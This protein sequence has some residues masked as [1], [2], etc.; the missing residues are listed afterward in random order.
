MTTTLREELRLQ[1][2]S[3]ETY[4]VY[5]RAL[6]TAR[7]TRRRVV[8]AGVAAIAG[9]AALGLTLPAAVPP[10]RPLTEA[11]EAAGA[12][13]D[14][15]GLPPYG[16]LHVVDRPHL[17]AAAVLF[18]GNGSRFGGWTDD[19]DEY[20]VVG[21][22][23]DAYRVLTVGFDSWDARDVTLSPDGRTVAAPAFDGHSPRLHLFDLAAGATRTLDLKVP[24]SQ[25]SS[26]IG[27]SPDNSSLIVE[28]AVSSGADVLGIVTVADG[29]W[30]KLA[31][32]D[33]GYDSAV[34][35]AWS[36]DE[37]RIAYQAKNQ[38]HVIDPTGRALATFPAPAGW[39]LAGKGAWT[40]DGRALAVVP[41]L[42]DHDWPMRYVNPATGAAHPGPLL[43]RLTTTTEQRANLLGWQPNGT[44]LVQRGT[45]ILALTPGAST[46]RT[47]LTAPPEVSTIDVATD[48]ILSGRTRHANPPW[49]LGPRFWFGAV[50]LAITLF[51]VRLGLIRRRRRTRNRRIVAVPWETTGGTLP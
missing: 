26:P 15:I 25:H 33:S 9:V 7:R 14:R 51:G 40:P 1:T 41:T 43:P 34:T 30:T 23:S 32:I 45:M 24:G 2:D 22:G 18:S 20:A 39:V 50:I 49:S 37:R 47:V 31:D 28:D 11:A 29:R 19:A 4:D 21:A 5:E 17:G 10:P 36:P 46:Q 12:L 38:I 8:V 42:P 6:A 16:A 13:P 35:V 48:V 3:A 44:A 27:W